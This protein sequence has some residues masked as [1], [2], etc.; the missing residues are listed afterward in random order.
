MATRGELAPVQLLRRAADSTGTAPFSL[1]ISAGDAGWAYSGLRVLSLAPGAPIRIETGGSE[2][3]VLPLSG[4][5][6]GGVMSSRLS[7][8]MRTEVCTS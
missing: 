8:W 3:L 5:V 1:D 2:T 7:R 6:G 4:S